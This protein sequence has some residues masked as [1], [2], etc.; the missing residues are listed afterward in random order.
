[1]GRIDIYSDHELGF[2]NNKIESFRAVRVYYVFYGRNAWH[3]TWIKRYTRNCFQP[4]CDSMQDVAERLRKRGSVLYAEEIPGIIVTSS[5]S[6][7]VLT[8]INTDEPFSNLCGTH[9]ASE[10]KTFFESSFSYKFRR[11]YSNREFLV[12]EHTML[13]DFLRCLRHDS[14]FWLNMPP[15]D[16]SLIAETVDTP[17][18]YS[19]ISSSPF[20]AWKGRSQ[21]NYLSLDWVEQENMVNPAHAQNLAKYLRLAKSVSSGSKKATPAAGGLACGGFSLPGIRVLRRRERGMI[22]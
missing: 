17:E 5:S 18:I 10:T 13:S 3:S 2:F 12:D 8:Q 7:V 14:T 11:K 15:K 6:N 9:Q 4:S 19:S 1:M 22:K 21:G 20:C 16:N